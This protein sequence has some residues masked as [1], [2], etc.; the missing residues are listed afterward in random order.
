MWS[1]S[2]GSLSLLSQPSLWSLAGF[3]LFGL[4]LPL[5]L[6]QISQLFLPLCPSFSFS[7]N[8]RLRPHSGFF[9]SSASAALWSFQ[10]LCAGSVPSAPLVLFLQRGPSRVERAVGVCCRSFSGVVSLSFAVLVLLRYRWCPF[11]SF[12][13]FLHS[14]CCNLSLSGTR[15]RARGGGGHV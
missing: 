4:S 5:F 1:V 3:R 9:N 12:P 11:L 6:S 8:S 14:P 7:F 13:L 10:L 15:P 2:L